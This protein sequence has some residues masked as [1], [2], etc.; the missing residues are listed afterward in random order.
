M[1]EDKGRVAL[2]LVPKSARVDIGVE[3]RNGLAGG[4]G[5]F[6]GGIKSV[7]VE[8]LN[9]NPREQGSIP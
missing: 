2:H 3:D 5:V 4:T 6:C 7:R 1:T 9:P 8:W